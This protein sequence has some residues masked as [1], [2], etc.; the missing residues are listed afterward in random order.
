MRHRRYVAYVLAAWAVACGG[1]NERVAPAPD[2]EDLAPNGC[3]PIAQHGCEA[4][5]KCASRLESL[6]PL[7][8]TAACV[9][10]GDAAAGQACALVGDPLAGEGYD[11]CQ[12]GLACERGRCTPICD[13]RAEG[14]CEQVS[15]RCVGMSQ[16]FDDHIGLCADTCHPVRQDCEFGFGDDEGEAGGEDGEEGERSIE[17]CYFHPDYGEGVCLRTARDA[18]E[19]VQGHECLGPVAGRGFLNGCAPGHGCLLPRT[20][21]RVECVFFCEP[22]AELDGAPC[23]APGGPGADGYECRYLRGWLGFGGAEIPADI[24]VCIP[25]DLD[26]LP[27]CA[28]DPEGLGC[29]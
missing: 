3:D 9:P 25:T 19:R 26:D 2:A 15:G 12:A 10:E 14:A 1:G 29:F 13:L 8:T 22:N 24:G 21:D 5:E 28:E 27:S 11:D 18:V 16:F 4:G 23:A 20:R 7:L 17:A 6:D